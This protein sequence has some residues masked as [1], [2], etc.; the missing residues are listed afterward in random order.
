MQS[1]NIIHA[2]SDYHLYAL[3]GAIRRGHEVFYPSPTPLAQ[4]QKRGSG[5]GKN[6]TGD[7]G[8]IVKNEHKWVKF[9]KSGE[10]RHFPK[11]L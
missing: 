4:T 10:K 11:F 1:F 9:E 3:Y 8:Q 7:L 5:A 6:C 2:G